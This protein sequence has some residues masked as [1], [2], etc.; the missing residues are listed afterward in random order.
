LS[1]FG[2]RKI[3]ESISLFYPVLVYIIPIAYLYEQS[4]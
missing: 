3:K 1:K 4:I 2:I